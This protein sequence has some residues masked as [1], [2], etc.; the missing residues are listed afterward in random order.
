MLKKIRSFIQQKT[1]RPAILL[2][3]SVTLLLMFL[4]NG[5]RLPFSNPTIAEHSGGVPI[6]DM[7]LSFS[8]DD[9]YELFSALGKEGR[10]A[11]L[12]LHLLPDMLFP[13]GYALVFAFISAW[14]LV[15][16]FPL[17]HH[18]QWMILIPLVSGLAD[19]MENL[20]LVVCNLAYPGRID[21]LVQLARVLNN[22]KFGLLP[23]GAVLLSVIVVIW[24]VQYRERARRNHESVMIGKYSACS[25]DDPRGRR[26]RR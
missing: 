22:V 14:F 4:M 23:V 7:R 13:I 5:T 10:R 19:L 15:R 1:G 20:S 9:A 11:Y 8:P 25:S 2:L 6:L 24:F 16:L 26:N 21:W 17:D 18:L 12:L 3:L